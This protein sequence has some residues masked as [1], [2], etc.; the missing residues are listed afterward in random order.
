[1]PQPYCKQN[2]LEWSYATATPA[3]GLNRIQ[4]HFKRSG[5]LLALSHP[6]LAFDSKMVAVRISLLLYQFACFTM[7]APFQL[8]LQATRESTK[9]LKTLLVLQAKT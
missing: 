8:H 2:W 5:V 3:G 1:M 6:S 4:W 7:R 9:S